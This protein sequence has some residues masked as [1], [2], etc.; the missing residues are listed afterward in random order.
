[1]IKIFTVKR[2]SVRSGNK[3]RL[4]HQACSRLSNDFK[5]RQKI[6]SLTQMHDSLSVKK[7]RI[8]IQKT[9]DHLS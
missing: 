5:K 2:S 4:Y 1:M 8:N 3:Y 9:I 7:C 6:I